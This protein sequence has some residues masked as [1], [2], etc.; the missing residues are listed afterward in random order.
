[1]SSVPTTPAAGNR[2]IC[3]VAH[4]GLSA[5]AGDW[6]HAGGIERQQTTM[7]VWLAARGWD[8]SMVVWDKPEIAVTEAEGVRIVRICSLV[9]GLPVLRFFHPRWTGLIAALRSA[10]ADIYYYN[11]GDLALGQIVAWARRRNRPVVFSVPSDP[12]CDPDLPSLHSR[13]ERI[14][15]RYGLTRCEHIIVQTGIQQAM[16]KSGFGKRSTLLKMPCVGF[17]DVAVERD[18]DD[19][20]Q[21][22]WVGRISEEK[23][24]HWVQELARRMPDIQF[25]IV[26]APNRDTDYSR[27]VLSD[28]AALP[29]VSFVGRVGH[30]QLG[31]YYAHSDVL[32][33]TSVYEGFPNVFLEAWSVGTPVVTTC[34]PD[35]LID[36]EGIGSSASDVDAMV[37][38]IG[39]L[40]GDAELHRRASAA[41]RDYFERNHR[42][43]PAM[44]AFERY[45]INVLEGQK[46]DDYV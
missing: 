33:C 41:S 39:R 14:L 10:D 23:R 20:F 13:R 30:E 37:E 31:A 22:V 42:L 26:G 21:V 1:M 40:A 17:G 6:R 43:D 4:Y 29:N 24:P 46:G 12:N 16:L 32:I 34:D 35:G 2:S 19:R 3:F 7:A 45:F 28:D 11:C 36:R 9:D 15:Y 44:Q 25:T 8:V 5:L 38:A 18:A 27:R